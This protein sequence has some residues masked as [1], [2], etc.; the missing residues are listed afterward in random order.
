MRR[1]C[2]AKLWDRSLRSYHVSEMGVL[3][4][5]RVQ[6]VGMQLLGMYWSCSVPGCDEKRLFEKSGKVIMSFLVSITWLGSMLFEG[7]LHG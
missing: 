1:L 2:A 3:V 6:G 7:K 5:M 4:A